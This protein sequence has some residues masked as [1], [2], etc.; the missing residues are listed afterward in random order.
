MSHHTDTLIP[1][2]EDRYRSAA[3]DC[4]DCECALALALRLHV[5]ALLEETDLDRSAP[6]FHSRAVRLTGRIFF[7][8]L[9]IR[10]RAIAERVAARDLWDLMII[11]EE[12]R[13]IQE[14]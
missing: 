7:R 8:V 4:L 11:A 12:R 6:L 2:A 9:Q 13:G 3:L 14:N 1:M 10:D 5:M